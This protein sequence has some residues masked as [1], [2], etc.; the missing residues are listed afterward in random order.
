VVLAAQTLLLAW[1]TSLYCKKMSRLQK[2]GPDLKRLFEANV[3]IL[4][5]LGSKTL[6]QLSGEDFGKVRDLFH[7]FGSCDSIYWT[8]A[9]KALHVA[10]PGLFVML[11]SDIRTMYHMLHESHDPA[12][13]YEEFMKSCND[14][15]KSL[16]ARTT[17]SELSLR[18]PSFEIMRFRRTLAKMIDEYNYAVIKPIAKRAKASTALSQAS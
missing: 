7:S 10:N 4:D 5:Q 14:I 8:G 13:C 18:H 9:S 16:A 11:D 2:V 6:G 15:A 3:A 12:T 17:E 1:N